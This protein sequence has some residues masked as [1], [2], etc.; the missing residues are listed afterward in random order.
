MKFFEQTSKNFIF[1]IETFLFGKFK[2][3]LFQ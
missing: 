1:K 3:E 2:Y